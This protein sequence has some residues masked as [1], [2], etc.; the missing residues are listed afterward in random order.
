MSGGM[1]DAARQDRDKYTAN[2]DNNAQEGSTARAQDP[3]DFQQLHDESDGSVAEV[4]VM[5]SDE[6]VESS[7]APSNQPAP[8]NVSNQQP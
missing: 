2:G 3:I 5:D 7:Q 8:T 1:E 4:V 6:E